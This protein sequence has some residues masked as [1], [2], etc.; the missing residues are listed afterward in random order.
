MSQAFMPRD[1]LSKNFEMQYDGVQW[2]DQSHVSQFAK[3]K[4]PFGAREIFAQ[5][6]IKL[7]NLL[8]HDL[9]SKDLLEIL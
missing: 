6:G 3:K 8:S 5:F 9:L 7:C 2:L 4:F 1:T